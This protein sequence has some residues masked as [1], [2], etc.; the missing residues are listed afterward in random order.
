MI[1]MY[2]LLKSVHK[3]SLKENKPVYIWLRKGRWNISTDKDSFVEIPT[4]V[5][6]NNEK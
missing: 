1:N 4:L 6:T 2:K 5:H 3:M